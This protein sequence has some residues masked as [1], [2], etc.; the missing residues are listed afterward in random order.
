[1][2]TEL[3]QIS[4][5]S[6]LLS[7]G[8]LADAPLAL[9]GGLFTTSHA[10]PGPADEVVSCL[11]ALR[12]SQGEWKHPLMFMTVFLCVTVLLATLVAVAFDLMEKRTLTKLFSD[13]DFSTPAIMPILVTCAFFSGVLM[14]YSK[15]HAS[16][17]P[18]WM[19]RAGSVMCDVVFLTPL[20]G[21]GLSAGRK[22]TNP[23]R[24]T[25]NMSENLGSFLA[26]GGVFAVTFM[27][28]M[29]LL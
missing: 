27:S 19:T 9:R 5:R 7:T 12:T 14:A 18:A 16:K 17:S 26:G 2:A 15:K 4:T 28:G 23:E 6:V 8:F 29:M 22:I 11:E 25:R 1:M 20:I 13:E 21:L 10:I 3:L 24:G